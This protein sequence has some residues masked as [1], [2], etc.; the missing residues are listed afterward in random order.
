MNDPN[1]K[2]PTV[3]ARLRFWLKV[4]VVL[5]I[6][7]VPGYFVLMDRSRPQA[8]GAFKNYQSSFRWAPP[9]PDKGGNPT[10]FPDATMWNVIYEPMDDFYFKHFPRSRQE[11]ERLRDYGYDIRDLR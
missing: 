1:P 9:M 10:K 4:A 5:C 7:Y 6:F 8:F 2:S 3:R 11:K